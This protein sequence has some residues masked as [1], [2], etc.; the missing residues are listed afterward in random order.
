MA[1]KPSVRYWNSRKAY[2]CEIDGTQHILAKGPNDGPKGPTYKAAVQQFQK[3][4]SMEADKGTDDYL[5]S[6]LLN[7][8]RAHLHK[9][10]KSGVPGVFEI[11]ARSFGTEYGAKKVCDLLPTDFDEWLSS[12]T[13]WNPTSQAHAATLIL[14]ARR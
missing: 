7:A 6:S 10:R 11:M 8:Y 9:T 2:C 3:L 12:Q 14:G 1:K 5:V 13:R 4:I